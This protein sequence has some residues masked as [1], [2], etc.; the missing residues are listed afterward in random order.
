M[1]KLSKQDKEQVMAVQLTY[2]D[3]LN[4]GHCKECLGEYMAER[5]ANGGESDQ[6]PQEV[7]A[8]ELGSCPFVYPDGTRASVVSVWCKKCHRL[9]WDSRHLTHII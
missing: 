1:K 5:E 6:S 8:Y 4:F 3:V 9:V 2:E 7:M